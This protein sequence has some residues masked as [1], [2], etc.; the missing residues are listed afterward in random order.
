MFGFMSVDGLD[1]NGA[2]RPSQVI[3]LVEGEALIPFQPV[4]RTVEVEQD[5]TRPFHCH[6]CRRGFARRTTLHTHMI[7]HEKH[8]R[9]DC[10]TC[11]K[12]FSHKPSLFLHQKKVH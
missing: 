11:V 4:Y 9:F 2:L 8:S 3:K 1:A 5:A 12:K 6:I 7:V 10:P